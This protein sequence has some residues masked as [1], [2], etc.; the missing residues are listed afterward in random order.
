[1][2][3]ISYIE[4]GSLDYYEAQKKCFTYFTTLQI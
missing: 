1:M 2:D 4:D 3:N